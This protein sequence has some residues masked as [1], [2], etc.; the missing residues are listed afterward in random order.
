MMLKNN[1]KYISLLLLVITVSCAKRGTITGGLKDTI[2]PALKIS[3]PE[4]FNTNFKGNEI[5]L[6]FDENVK[7]KNLNKQLVIS[8]PMKYEPFHRR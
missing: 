8:P 7:L 2:A 3:F 5:K 6:V 4:N 1:L